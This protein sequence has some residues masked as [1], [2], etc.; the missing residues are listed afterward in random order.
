MATSKAT[1][2]PLFASVSSHVGPE[3]AW[4]L[5]PQHRRGGGEF[6]SRHVRR[7]VSP[8]RAQ[9]RRTQKRTASGDRCYTVKE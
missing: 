5:R 4:W 6:K 9:A 3:Q 1:L 2:G 7:V 8:P